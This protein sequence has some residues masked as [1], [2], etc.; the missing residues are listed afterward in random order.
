MEQKT[1]S[2]NK[3]EDIYQ[4]IL[5]KFD[6]ISDGLDEQSRLLKQ[7]EVQIKENNK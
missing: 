4:R 5:T 7:I 6:K 2:N 3:T 1:L